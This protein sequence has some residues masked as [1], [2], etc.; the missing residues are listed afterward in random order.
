MP[1]EEAAAFDRAVEQAVRP[2]TVDG[3]LEMPIVATLAWG[4]PRGSQ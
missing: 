3:V 2:W 4:R 1:A